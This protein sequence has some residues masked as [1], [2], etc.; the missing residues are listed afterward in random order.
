MKKII[1]TS[2]II[3]LISS[4]G[5]TQEKS[6]LSREKEAITQTALNYIEGWYDGNPER[7]EKALHKDLAKRGLF[8]NPQTRKTRM[9]SATAD[10]MVDYTK[11]GSGKKPKDQWGIKLKIFDIY[12]NTATVKIV[13]VDLIDFAHIGKIDGEWKIINVLWEPIIKKK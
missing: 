4:L 8:E 2:I 3:T 10:N 5:I 1:C 12:K 13:S 11:A 6:D 7:M 9:Q